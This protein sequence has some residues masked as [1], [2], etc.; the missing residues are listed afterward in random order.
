MVLFLFLFPP[1][2]S[3]LPRH[4][5]ERAFPEHTFFTLLSSLSD[6]NHFHPHLNP[7]KINSID[8]ILSKKSCFFS[9]TLSFSLSPSHAHTLISFALSFFRSAPVRYLVSLDFHEKKKNIVVTLRRCLVTGCC[10]NDRKCCRSASGC[11]GVR[12]RLLLSVLSKSAEKLAAGP[13]PLTSLFMPTNQLGTNT[14]DRF[15][16]CFSHG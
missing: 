6:W 9:L 5:S 15:G 13:S 14:V 8:V 10:T 11:G 2:S 7:L 1:H 12:R 3:S 16:V 4:W